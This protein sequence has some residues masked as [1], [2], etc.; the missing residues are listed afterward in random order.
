[1]VDIDKLRDKVTENK[2]TMEKLAYSL[3]INKSTLYRKINNSGETFT[4]KEVDKLV[5]VLN[6]TLE[7]SN[8]IF[9]S[10]FVA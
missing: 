1:M 3:N 5:R 10:Q 7:E 2:L 6:L 9:F 8:A 4:I